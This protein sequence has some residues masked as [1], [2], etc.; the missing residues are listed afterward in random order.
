MHQPT[1]KSVF[2]RTCRGL[3]CQIHNILLENKRSVRLSGLCLPLTEQTDVS[4]LNKDHLVQLKLHSD[5]SLVS[6]SAQY[7][8]SD[9]Q[10]LLRLCAKGNIQRLGGRMVNFMNCLCKTLDRTDEAVSN[11]DPQVSHHSACL[12]QTLLICSN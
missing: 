4:D 7:S 6:Q 3:S 2:G 8:S 1:M 11:P 12:C 5:H 10:V 9:I